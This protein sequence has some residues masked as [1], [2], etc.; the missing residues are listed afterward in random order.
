[1]NISGATSKALTISALAGPPSAPRSATGTPGNAQV[2]VSWAASLHDGGSAITG[3]TVT[4]SPGGATCSAAP[5]TTECVVTGLTNGT[6]YAFTVTA[7]NA[8][9][10]S[11]ASA[12]VAATPVYWDSRT[13]GTGAQFRSVAWNGSMWVAVGAGGTIRTSTNGTD[14]S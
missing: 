12:P 4:A 2:A 1:A 9:G 8:A 13:S 10:T 7:S 5:P 3:Y 6:E 11:L 14:W